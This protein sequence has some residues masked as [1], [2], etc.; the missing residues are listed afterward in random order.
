[1]PKLLLREDPP[2]VYSLPLYVTP[3]QSLLAFSITE[4]PSTWLSSDASG[5]G[6]TIVVK[7]EVGDV[8]VVYRREIDQAHKPEQR[9][10]IDGTADLSPFRGQRIVLIVSTFSVGN[11]TPSPGWGNLS[12]KSG[13]DVSNPQF[14]RVYDHEATIYENAHAYPRAFFVS[15]LIATPNMN[16]AVAAMKGPGINPRTMA[17]VEGLPPAVQRE[18]YPTSGSAI[19]RQDNS[20]GVRIDVSSSARAFLVLSDTYYPGWIARVDGRV[21]PIFPVDLAFRGIFVPS[22][23]HLVEFAYKPRP[24][25]EGMAIAGIGLLIVLAVVV[26]P[27]AIFIKAKS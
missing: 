14:T 5:V 9:H 22:G 20:T 11:S 4:L 1:M 26:R 3:S 18:N 16:T 8:H 7:D 2:K 10:W 17:I 25:E 12:L 19:V 6:F 24:F 27:W 21:V 15:Q 13:S 23:Q